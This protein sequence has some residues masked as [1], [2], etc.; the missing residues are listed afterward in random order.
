[1]LVVVV[2]LIVVVV[3]V[4]MVVV[5]SIKCRSGAAY[6]VILSLIVK[7]KLCKILSHYLIHMRLAFCTL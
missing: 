6:L 2:I 5:M 7:N 1:M 3:V 4:I